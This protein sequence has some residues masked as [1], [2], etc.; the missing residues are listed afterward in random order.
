MY[1]KLACIHVDVSDCAANI[2]SE[3]VILLDSSD[4]I[5]HVIFNKMIDVAVTLINRL[6]LHV[7]VGAVSYSNNVVTISSV[8][9]S[10]LRSKLTSVIEKT[11]YVGGRTGTDLAIHRAMSLLSLNAEQSCN[12]VQRSMLIITDGK[13]NSML[14]SVDAAEVAKRRHNVHIYSLP[15]GKDVDERELNMLVSHPHIDYIHRISNFED[16]SD[17]QS[18]LSKFVNSFC[19]G[20]PIT[21]C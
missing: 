16:N 14:S 12:K 9:G 13:S 18:V 4:S 10:H 6:P 1:I 15:V 2:D 19:S 5:G 8:V 3:L 21:Q 7:R 17:V 20:E 11:K